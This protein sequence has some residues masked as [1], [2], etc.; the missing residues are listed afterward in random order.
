MP[1]CLECGKPFIAKHPSQKFC[2]KNK[3]GAHVCKDRYHNRARFRADA[4]TPARRKYL[5]RTS[6]PGVIYHN[7]GTFQYLGSFGPWD[8]HKDN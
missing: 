2:P 8:D 4:I 5:D 3:R 6:E 7:D 1:N